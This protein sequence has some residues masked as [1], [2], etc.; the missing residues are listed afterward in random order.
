MYYGTTEI[1]YTV[2]FYRKLRDF[3]DSV[4]G[5]L[6]T[7]SLRVMFRPEIPSGIPGEILYLNYSWILLTEVREIFQYIHCT[8]CT[9]IKRFV[10]LSSCV[11]HYAIS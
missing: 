5:T 9:L 6:P 11:A 8:Y 4:R 3:S 10:C 2:L 7:R 1:T